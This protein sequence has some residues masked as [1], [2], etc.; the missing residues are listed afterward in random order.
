MYAFGLRVALLLG[1]DRLVDRCITI[2]IY[3]GSVCMEILREA[4][5]GVLVLENDGIL[6]SR[7]LTKCIDQYATIQEFFK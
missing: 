7:M 6:C 2:L 5:L 4:S 3:V 1:T